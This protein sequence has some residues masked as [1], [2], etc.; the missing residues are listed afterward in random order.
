MAELASGFVLDEGETLVMEIEAEPW[1][2][3]FNR[4]I[5]FIGQMIRFST[6]ML[7][8]WVRR[9]IMT[10]RLRP[11]SSRMTLFGGFIF[12]YIA[13]ISGFWMRRDV[14]VTKIVTILLALASNRVAL[15]IGFVLKYI[16]LIF[17]FRTK[18][19]FVITDKR[20][21]EMWTKFVC[22]C[23]PME[24]QIQ[25]VTLGSV[26]KTGY[27]Q[28]KICYF[29]WSVN[30]LYYRATTTWTFIQ[31][32]DA[33]EATALKAIDAFYAVICTANT[34]NKIDNQTSNQ[35]DNQANSQTDSQVTTPV[36]IVKP[37]RRPEAFLAV[38]NTVGSPQTATKNNLLLPIIIG[39][40]AVLILSVA[41][42]FVLGGRNLNLS[43]AGSYLE[44]KIQTVSASS[45]RDV[46]QTPKLEPIKITKKE[47]FYIPIMS[48][49]GF[50]KYV[51]L[52]GKE[53]T[54]AK[55]I[56]AYI[57]QEGKALVQ[58]K[59]SLWSYIDMSGNPI[60]GVYKQALSFKDGTAWVNDNGAIKALG[61]NGKAI[62]TLP[63]DIISVWSFYDG[64]ALFSMDGGQGYLDKNLNVIGDGRLFT[65]GNRF[66]E[67]AASVMCDNGKYGYINVAFDLVIDCIFD[68][69]KV[70]KNSMAIVKRG[71]GWGV[72]NKRGDYIFGPFSGVEVI[73]TD[74]NMFKFKRDGKWGWLNSEGEI[75]IP[76]VYE[77]I[78]SFDD[79]D[80]APVK[81]NG[82]WGYIDKNGDY[83]IDRQYDIAYPFFNNRAVVK[84][85]EQF[86]TVDKNGMIDLRTGSQRIDPSYWNFINSGVAGGPRIMSTEP[87][88]KCDASGL[89]DAEKIICRS[90]RLAELDKKTNDRYKRLS[91]TNR[92]GMISQKDFLANR[93]RCRTVDCIE[94]AYE[95]R[96]EEFDD[97]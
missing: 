80:I 54:E 60:G 19:F 68:E 43:N 6:L 16:A 77:E 75:I 66:Q 92:S 32:K 23:I 50:Y 2:L 33:D 9:D 87:S 55:Y 96:N 65:D 25:N 74:D 47:L 38:G 46:L 56:R 93:N 5:H 72:I 35:I 53:I 70:F 41:G 4:I 95:S 85:D 34:D 89:S 59:D 52:D 61:S 78:M 39:V 21:V 84:I 49:N 83:V 22:W 37:S 90:V 17:G 24:R 8:F 29:F 71:N 40:A 15:F 7:G 30:C 76:A 28:T 62:K 73:N 48:G 57:F 64:I 42:F 63:N 44:G 97:L 20:V 31:M 51:A 26:E 13:L 58:R 10:T 88:F 86:V 14:L 11:A 3:G 69:A 45:S 91:G 81:Q 18:R 94:S 79:R 36:N 12:K 27:I 1:A 67:G 82:L